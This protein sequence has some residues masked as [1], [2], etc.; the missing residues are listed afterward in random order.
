MP[1]VSVIIPTYNRAETLIAALQSV[2]TQTYRDF[3]IIVVDDGSTDDTFARLQPYMD[4]I[5]YV[6]QENRGAS[7]AQNT[8][9]DLAAGTWV[10]ILASDD[11]WLP[12]KLEK[13]L[14][15]L[16]MFGDGYGA[17]FTD[18]IYVGD[19]SLACSVFEQ[20]GLEHQPVSASLSRAALRSSRPS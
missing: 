13:E 15:A 17:C 4:C 1:N 9:I 5:R 2:L 16:E 18:C 20:A 14:K 10:S 6:Y 8:G 19:P 7:A 12:T 3:E 11:Q